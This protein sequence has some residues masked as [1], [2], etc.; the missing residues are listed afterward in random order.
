MLVSRRFYV[1]RASPHRVGA[2]EAVALIG[3]PLFRWPSCHLPKVIFAAKRIE[4][5]HFAFRII[6]PLAI[7]KESVAMRARLQV[8]SCVPDTFVAFVQ[9]DGMLFP[10]GEISY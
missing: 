2:S 10:M 5:A 9:A 1:F 8:D 4:Y 7:H 6:A 3:E